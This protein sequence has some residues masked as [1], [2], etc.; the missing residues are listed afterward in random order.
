MKIS[1]FNNIIDMILERLYRK[2][3]AIFF[4]LLKFRYFKLWSKLFFKYNSK[5]WVLHLINDHNPKMKVK[6]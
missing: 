4:A 2:F 5:I 3:G 1:L 6:F